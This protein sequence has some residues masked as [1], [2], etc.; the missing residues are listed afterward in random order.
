MKTIY[1]EIRYFFRLLKHGVKNLWRWFPV[2]W[3]D[4]D[5]D[6][7][8]IFEILKFKIKNTAEYIEDSS[9]FVGYEHEVSRM[10]LVNKLIGLI[11][12]QYYDMEFLDYEDTTYEFIP[13][14]AVDENGKSDY[15]EMKS[16][17]I[18]DR[19]DDYF[20]KYP[21]IY[22]KVINKLG[23]DTSRT[24]IALYMSHENHERAKRLLFNILHKHIENW[25]D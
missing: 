25:W 23:P 20:T 14:D 5:Y 1:I 3:K 17:V 2:I 9:F 16:E 7:H 24:K 4:K 10:R 13:S 22:K 21:L 15:Y 6:D 18:E 8:F 11:Q 12:S 19:L